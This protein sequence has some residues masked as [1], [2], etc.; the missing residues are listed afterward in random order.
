MGAIRSLEAL[1]PCPQEPLNSWELWCSGFPESPGSL[2]WAKNPNAPRGP[3]VLRGTRAPRVPR[4]APRDPMC[5]CLFLFMSVSVSVYLRICV[6]MPPLPIRLVCSLYL[7]AR[8]HCLY[9]SVCMYVCAWVC[10]CVCMRVY[11]V[12]ISVS[13][14]LHFFSCLF[15]LSSCVLYLMF[16]L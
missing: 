11:V 5:M 7:L 10:L 15:S 4:G 3:R 14:A 9:V 6:C 12:Y 2:G 8:S 13:C 16:C 1:P